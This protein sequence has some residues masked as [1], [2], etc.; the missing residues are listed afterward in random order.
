MIRL[1]GPARQRG[2]TLLELIVVLMIVGLMSAVVAPRLIDALT[3]ANLKTEAKKIAASLRYARS[4]A[5]TEKKTFRATF[6][7]DENAMAVYLMDDPRSGSD[8]FLPEDEEDGE[9]EEAEAPEEG[10]SGE[11][12]ETLVYRL[13]EGV[14]LVKT[15]EIESRIEDEQY[16]I[17]FHPGGNSSG[18][19]VTL[20]GEKEVYYSLRVDFITGSVEME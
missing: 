12:E 6:S 7:F 19:V 11:S 1:P 4:R 13:P 20:G 10:E 18:G 16:H 17:D 2:F 8:D 14:L 3:G 9:A 15:E 5:A